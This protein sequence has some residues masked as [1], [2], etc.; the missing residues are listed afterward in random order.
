MPEKNH[1]IIRQAELDLYHMTDCD[2]SNALT[3]SGEMIKPIKTLDNSGLKNLAMGTASTQR[4][5]C[6]L[7]KM[8][9]NSVLTSLHCS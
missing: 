8:E 9:D 4:N 3:H 7:G 1:R 6:Y 5:L 2:S